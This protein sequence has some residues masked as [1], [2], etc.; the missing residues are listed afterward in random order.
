MILGVIIPHRTVVPV[1][2]LLETILFAYILPLMT[3]SFCMVDGCRY[4]QDVRF[5]AEI[6]FLNHQSTAQ[7]Y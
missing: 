4:S 1:S 7:E 2:L 3:V 5:V 6:Y